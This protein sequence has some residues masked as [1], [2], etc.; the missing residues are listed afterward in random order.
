MK[1]SVLANGYRETRV[2]YGGETWPQKASMEAGVG[3][4][5]LTS[6]N[7]SVMQTEQTRSR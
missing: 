5:E 2:H 7:A 4:R 3:S 1:E 6:S